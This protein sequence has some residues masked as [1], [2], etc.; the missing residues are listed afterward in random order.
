VDY[1]MGM[2]VARVKN[3]LPRNIR[4]KSAAG[5]TSARKTGRWISGR[6]WAA[7]RFPAARPHRRG[8]NRSE[9]AALIVM[10]EYG[11][12]NL[13]PPLRGWAEA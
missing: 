2:Q 10:D 6:S 4:D 9:N 8:S 3:I 12:R 11:S 7:I 13:I 1:L 5:E